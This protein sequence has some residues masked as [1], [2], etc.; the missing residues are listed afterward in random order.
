M[1][2]VI[3]NAR[4]GK[5]F[6]SARLCWAGRG[7][8]EGVSVSPHKGAG[9]LRARVITPSVAALQLQETSARKS[10]L[11]DKGSYIYRERGCGGSEDQRGAEASLPRHQ[12]G[13]R[14]LQLMQLHTHK[15]NAHA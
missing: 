4:E 2:E 14:T 5:G 12:L 7:R 6:I 9:P 1:V 10:P 13:R 15:Q 11:E 8:R 3:S